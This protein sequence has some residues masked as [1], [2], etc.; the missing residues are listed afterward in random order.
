LV[1]LKSGHRIEMSQRQSA[2]FRSMMDL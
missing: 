1:E 2:K